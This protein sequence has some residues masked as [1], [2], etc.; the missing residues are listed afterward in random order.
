M[1]P[2]QW[3]MRGGRH[4]PPRRTGTVGKGS[5]TIGGVQQQ[6][7]EVKMRDDRDLGDLV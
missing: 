5:S 3:T 7:A 2:G 1:R 6:H 4:V